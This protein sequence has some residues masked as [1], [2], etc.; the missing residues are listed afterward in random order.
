M[1]A[2]TLPRHGC[3]EGFVLF[4]P[5]AFPGADF[6]G[7]D[8]VTCVPDSGI[9]ATAGE[10]SDRWPIK[11][12]SAMAGVILGALAMFEFRRRSRGS[13]ATGSEPEGRREAI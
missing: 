11:L 9:Y 13:D 7:A 2:V 6:P 8:A 3:S 1:V 5:R 12:A 10:V 4:D